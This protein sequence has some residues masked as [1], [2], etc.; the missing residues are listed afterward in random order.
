MAIVGLSLSLTG[1]GAF[2]GVPLAI[3]G[4]GI[5][6]AGGATTGV[7]IG[8]EAFL[9][10]IGITE[11]E[12]Y[13]ALDYFKSEQIKVLLMR[14]SMNPQFAERWQIESSQFLT[15][16][17]ILPRLA[18]LGVTTAAGV[19]VAFGMGR[20]ATTAGLHVAG[21]V[22]AA[23]VIPLDLTQMIISSI[24]VHKKEPSKVIKDIMSIAD[25][26]EKQLRVFLIGEGYFQFIY[27]NDG[28]WMY[29]IIHAE[30]LTL[31]KDGLRNGFTVAQLKEFGDVVE[32]GEGDVPDCKRKRIQHEWYSCYDELVAEALQEELQPTRE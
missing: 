15:A 13:L 7:T 22:L 23:A 29:V 28:H 4:A 12:N 2:V 9:Q 26:L 18:K 16:G 8:I 30:K 3:T 10:K 24:R 17:A 5:G 19:R 21:F 20:A 14:A 32:S 27:T 11:A 31:F 6:V 1:F 25:K